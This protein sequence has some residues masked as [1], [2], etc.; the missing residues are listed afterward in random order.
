MIH[1]VRRRGDQSYVNIINDVGP[2]FGSES[3]IVFYSRL[4]CRIKYD[5]NAFGMINYGSKVLC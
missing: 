2:E 3:I 5:C 1:A 4:D